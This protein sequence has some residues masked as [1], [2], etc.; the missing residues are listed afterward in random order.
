MVSA[1]DGH[2]GSLRALGH[3]GCLGNRAGDHAA[4]ENA[5]LAAGRLVEDASLT[6]RHAV[7]AADQFNF[8]A[9]GAGPQPRRLRRTRRA[10]FD[11]HF[12]IFFNRLL[13]R[14]VADPVHIAQADAAGAQ[15]LARTDNDTERGGIEPHD[16]ERRTGG[17]TEPAALPNSEMNNAIVLA[18]HGPLKIDNVAGAGSTR[19]QP[20]DHFRIMPA[21]HEA[22]VLAVVLVSD[23]KPEAA[24]QL[25]R[26]RLGPIAKRET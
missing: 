25:T 1:R 10:D 2:R 9:A 12:C 8:D 24:R 11:K 21:R 5:R 20:L 15:W 14:P 4:A 6:G 22:D 3:G 26:F 17:N 23:R 7:F 18:E 16:I 19:P 13:D